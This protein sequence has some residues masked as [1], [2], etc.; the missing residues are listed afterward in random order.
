MSHE[1]SNPSSFN[2]RIRAQRQTVQ[3]GARVAKEAK[4][5]AEQEMERLGSLALEIGQQAVA[6]LV[7][8]GVPNLPIL[9]PHK[10]EFKDVESSNPHTPG[11]INRHTIYENRET[12]RGWRVS[13]SS[14]YDDGHYL[15]ATW[16]GLKDS[17]E[18]LGVEGDYGSTGRS[19]DAIVNPKYITGTN[20]HRE[21]TSNQFEMGIANLI[22]FGEPHRIRY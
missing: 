3:D 4:I 9:T 12:A 5:A 19:N 2:E 1:S 13:L 18:L 14:F 16:L 11:K 21:I 7:E 10:I 20:A 22:E 17:G 8:G 6:L 15:P